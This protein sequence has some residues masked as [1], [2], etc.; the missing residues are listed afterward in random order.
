[1][2]I[3]FGLGAL[4]VLKV[5]EAGHLARIEPF[6]HDMFIALGGVKGGWG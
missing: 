6:E 5:K 1:M 2:R 4:G 3:D